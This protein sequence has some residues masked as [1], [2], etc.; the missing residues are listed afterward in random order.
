[1]G[2]LNGKV[3]FITGGAR[4]Q[5]RAIAH[6]F[7][8]EGANIVTCDIDSNLDTISYPLATRDDMDVTI[9][10]VGATGREIVAE[11]ADVRSQEQLDRVV[12]RGIEAFG[13][14]DIVVANAGIVDYRPFWE[15]SEPQ[16]RDVVDVCMTGAWR[17]AKACAPLMIERGQGVMVFTSSCNGVEG[18]WNYMSYIAAKHGVMGIM[19]SAALELAPHNVRVHA[20]LPGPIDTAMNDNE[21]GRDR[22]VG[23]DGATRAQYLAAVRSWHAL[24]GRTALPAHVVADAMIWL[25][26]DEARHAT[27]VELVIDAGHMLLPGMNPSP[28]DDGDLITDDPEQVAVGG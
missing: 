17:T 18:G 13:Q 4:G 28:I 24:R 25:V 8:S 11:I 23:R 1:M 26:S 22:I 16:W 27:G 15:I 9:G 20:V 7:A 19:R 6:K 14:I 5:G 21:G 3:A 12:E 10:M 2:R